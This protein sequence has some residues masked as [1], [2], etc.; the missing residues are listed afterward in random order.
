MDHGLTRRLTYIM[1][2]IGRMFPRAR[3]KALDWALEK[4]MKDIFPRLDPDWRLLPA[5]PDANANAVYNE[6]IIDAFASGAVESIRGLKQFTGRGVITDDEEM[7]EVDAVIFA[8]GYHFNYSNLGLTADPTQTPTP[9]WDASNHQNGLP[10]PR[11]YQT[12]FSPDYPLSLAFIGPCQGYTFAAFCHADLASQAITQ[13][14]LGNFTLPDPKGIARWCDANYEYCLNQIREWRVAKTGADNGALETWLN[15]AAGNGLDDHLGW[16]LQAWRFWWEDRE[17][18]RMVMN[19]VNTP[20]VYRL[21]EGR[22]G[23][24]KP[25]SGARDAIFKANDRD[26]SA[27]STR[28]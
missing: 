19:G 8:T 27:S 4:R 9:E 2:A 12:L 23:S 1:R 11:L 26:L 14:W 3:G 25:W 17:L 21:F 6:H 24:R 5:P 16:G 13:V 7:L 15:Q 28:S 10:Y 18:Y 22:P 20:F